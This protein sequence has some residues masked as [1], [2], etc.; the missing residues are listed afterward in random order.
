MM[1]GG[2]LRVQR[3]PPQLVV[4]GGGLAPE[5]NTER[6]SVIE[7]GCPTRHIVVLSEWSFLSNEPSGGTDLSLVVEAIG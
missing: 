1:Y 3:R 6:K 5:N 4:D 2:N 7:I